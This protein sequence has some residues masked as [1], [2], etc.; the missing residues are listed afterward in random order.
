MAALPAMT[1]SV[2]MAQEKAP[3]EVKKEK[4]RFIWVVESSGFIGFVIVC[5]SGYFVA[6]V[7]KLFMKMKPEVA[8]PPALIASCEEKLQARDFK[9]IYEMVQQ[10]DSFFSRVV[11]VGITELPNGLADAREAMQRT[12]EAESAH[13][14]KQIS[15]LAV[16]GTL[17]PMIG[18][19]GTLKGMISSFSVIALSGT[20]LRA[21]QVA[22]G[23]SEAL[24]LTFEGVS[25][26][27][28][29]IFFF[30]IFRNRVTTITASVMLQA[31]QILRHFSQAMRGGGKK[32][33][34]DK[35]TAKTA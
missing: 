17:G 21:D 29:A 18:L 19:L 12:G 22:G 13:M 27:V 16:L 3:E 30:A 25:L 28:P 6:T 23:I 1:P 14:E 32:A 35:T 7:I 34:A 31:D 33:P 4:N 20:Q 5:C 9:G 2:A 8:A 10:D 26:S 24:I 11:S 15:M